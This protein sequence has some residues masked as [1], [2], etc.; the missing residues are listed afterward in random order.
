[1]AWAPQPADRRIIVRP[2]VNAAFARAAIDPARSLGPGP[3]AVAI[4]IAVVLSMLA[5]LIPGVG[6]LLGSAGI[7]AAFAGVLYPAMRLRNDVVGAP[8]WELAGRPIRGEA[9]EMVKDIHDRFAYAHRVV[10]DIPTGIEWD[11]VDHDVRTLL[12]E[13]ATQA[14]EV[15]AL[16]DQI[17]EMRYAAPGTPQAALL[18]RLNDDRAARWDQLIDIQW[19][20]ETLARQAGNAVAAARLAMTRTGSAAALNIVVPSREALRAKGALNEVRARLTMLADVW[21][22]LDETGAIADESL[23]RAIEPGPADG[24][25]SDR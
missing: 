2:G 24:T 11:E 17:V 20:A 4:V 22:S 14:V 25:S 10:D 15:T 8:R 3:Y 12:W 21:A 9:L 5:F 6:P 1:M 13:A 19:E 7:V 23:R 18:D 16:D